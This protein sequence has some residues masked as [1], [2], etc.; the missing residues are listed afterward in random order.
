MVESSPADMSRLA[1]KGCQRTVW[2]DPSCTLSSLWNTPKLD[3]DLKSDT[4]S[5]ESSPHEATWKSYCCYE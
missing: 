4:R 1:S 5:F 3:G 2:H